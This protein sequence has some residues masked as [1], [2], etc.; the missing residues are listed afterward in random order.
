MKRKPYMGGGLLAMA[1]VDDVVYRDHAQPDL[2]CARIT[3]TTATRVY[4]G[5]TAYYRS[6][7]SQVGGRSHR[8][9]MA[10][11]KEVHTWRIDAK[12]AKDRREAAKQL[13]A[14]QEAD[15]AWRLAC[16]ILVM[17]AD[18]LCRALGAT[19]SELLGQLQDAIECQK[20]ATR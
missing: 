8:I 4:V 17:D 20:A 15:P 2:R 1:V 18:T 13:R 9:R 16:S 5:Q 14:E 10:T 12:A 6:D 3:H 19:D 11:E 7:G